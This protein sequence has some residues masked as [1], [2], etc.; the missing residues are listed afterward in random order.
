MKNAHG[1]AHDMEPQLESVSQDMNKEVAVVQTRTHS[2]SLLQEQVNQQLCFFI[3]LLFFY[4][5]LII[6]SFF[7]SNI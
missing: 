4:F 7:V 1:L 6:F 3:D 5:V 2:E